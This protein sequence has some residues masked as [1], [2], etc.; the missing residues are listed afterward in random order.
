MMYR[1]NVPGYVVLQDGTVY[2]GFGFAAHGQ[3]LGEVVFNTGMTGYQ[4]IVT[5]PSYH[6]QMVTFTYP[7]VGNYGA[8]PHLSE[9][10]AVHSKAIIVR[11]IKN[12]AWNATCSEGWVD[13]LT[14][15][16]VVGVGGIDT[17]ALTRRIREQGAMPACVAAGEDLDAEALVEAAR[18][19]PSMVGRDLASVV[20]CQEPY[21]WSPE[22]DEPIP[23]SSGTWE[24]VADTGSSGVSE[25]QFRVVAFDYGIKKSILRNLSAVG[26]KVLVVPARWTAAQVLALQPDG[27]FLSNGPGDPAA[28]DYA[29]QTIRGLLGRVPIFGICLGH[30]LLALAV[31]FVT[32]KLKF[33]HRGINHPVRNYLTGRVE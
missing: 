33:G 4:E 29:V 20:T 25:R 3:V 23:V 22:K 17:R 6:G 27:V 7:L 1:S 13:W 24:P 19:C 28:V 8:G 16:G 9:S 26:C 30:Q 32:Y 11:E 10:A 31:G 2:R 21:L 18:S 5:D 14:K 15:R 12:T